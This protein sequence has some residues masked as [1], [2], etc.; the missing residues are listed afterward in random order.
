M[1]EVRASRKPSRSKTFFAAPISRA[2]V[3][4][5]LRERGPFWLVL[6]LAVAE[7]ATAAALGTSTL[8]SGSDDHLPPTP[9]PCAVAQC[10]NPR[11]P[12]RPTPGRELRLAAVTKSPVA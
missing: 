4:T 10:A 7:V 5:P 8:F 9:Y 2:R 3:S 1:A 6:V 11:R 12:R